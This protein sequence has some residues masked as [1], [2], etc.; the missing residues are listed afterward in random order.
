MSDEMWES[1]GRY[2]GDV[3]RCWKIFR[4][5]RCGIHI[6]VRWST[7]RVTVNPP[8]CSKPNF[9]EKGNSLFNWI[10]IFVF[11]REGS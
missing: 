8:Y 2:A 4:R 10:G 9:I 7:L 3:G 5:K 1:M 11:V 6:F